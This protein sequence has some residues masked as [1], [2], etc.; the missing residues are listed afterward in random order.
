MLVRL[1]NKEG[2]VILFEYEGKKKEGGGVSNMCS[3]GLLLGGFGGYPGN[4]LVAA[5]IGEAAE[6]DLVGI[7]LSLG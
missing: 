3:A 1:L 2:F 7:V 4:E 6:S 5:R